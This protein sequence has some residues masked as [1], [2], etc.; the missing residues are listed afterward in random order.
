M[1]IVC[2]E[3]AAVDIPSH[4]DQLRE[5]RR[6]KAFQKFLETSKLLA[7]TIA[8]CVAGYLLFSSPYVIAHMKEVQRPELLLRMS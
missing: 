7:A 1:K 8:L 3:Y 2:P 5:R 6:A 4:P